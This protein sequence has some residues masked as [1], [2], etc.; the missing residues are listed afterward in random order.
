MSELV[1]SDACPRPTTLPRRARSVRA[2]GTDR[3]G[4]ASLLTYPRI[5]PSAH[6]GRAWIG[7]RELGWAHERIERRRTAAA[8]TP[9]AAARARSSFIGS[10]RST[11]RRSAAPAAA[12]AASCS[13]VGA[14]VAGTAAAAS[15]VPRGV[16][17]GLRFGVPCGPRPASSGGW[18]TKASASRQ[19]GTPPSD[20]L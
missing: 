2:A 5:Y 12:P 14:A 18:R 15:G 13:S 17:A 4:R 9:P 10:R 8:P 16:V 1:D 3:R 19:S 6:C 7:R 11:S 20:T